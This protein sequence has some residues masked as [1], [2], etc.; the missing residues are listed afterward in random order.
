M[1]S[2]LI[3]LVVTLATIVFA[4]S[5][6]LARD[7]SQIIA[8]GQLR[9]AIASEDFLPWIGRD[10][11]GDLLGFEVDV[12]NKFA[13]GLGVSVNF[14]EVPF[15]DLIASLSAKEV[16]IIISALSI[17]P[18]RARRVMFSRPYGQ[19]D[20]EMMVA[21]PLLPEA[22]VENNYDMKGIKIAVIR[23]TTSEF[24]AIRRFPKSEIITFPDR[25]AARDAF[26]A[27]E[28][29]SI[30]ATKPYPTF[31]QLRDPNNY[32]IIGTPLTSTVEAVAVHPENQRL[33]NYANS[34][35]YAEIASGYLEEATHY[36]FETLDW[37]DQVPGLVEQVNK[38]ISKQPEKNNNEAN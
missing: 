38:I 37:I 35:I 4:N 36:W 25:N 34:W 20:L 17:T 16:D 7:L 23:H 6:T 2:R 9:V 5:T 30:I 33:L 14:I 13:E 29:N 10:K 3:I 32:K 18:K 24:E 26:L 21:E 8:S 11:Q 12:A 22:A 19:S 28:V 15:G 27:G 31:I 1:A